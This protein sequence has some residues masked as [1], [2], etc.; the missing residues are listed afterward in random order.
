MRLSSLQRMATGFA[1]APAAHAPAQP[2][3]GYSQNVVG[4]RPSLAVVAAQSVLLCAIGTGLVGGPIGVNGE[5]LITATS[6]ASA[7]VAS[8]APL[9][10]ATPMSTTT[11]DNHKHGSSSGSGSVPA[12]ISGSDI[13][14]SV[15]KP[16][17][18]P[19]TV[20][21][22]VPG[23]M[24]EDWEQLRGSI[25]SRDESMTAYTIFCA[26]GQPSCFLSADAPFVFTE[27]PRSFKYTGVAEPTFTQEIHCSFNVTSAAVCAGTSTV[28]S[29][30][31]VGTVTGPAT[32]SWTK[33]YSS[34]NIT[35]VALTLATPGPHVGTTDIDGTAVA[36]AT[37]GDPYGGLGSEGLFAPT[38]IPKS[39]AAKGWTVEMMGRLGVV[40]AGVVGGMLML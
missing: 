8:A 40:V 18:E 16:A 23:Y 1:A 35:W 28:G 4:R 37:S 24:K 9:D 26:E 29:H 27:G 30:Y 11:A 39:S 32:S 36:S 20:S 34:S 13:I 14:T 33:T 21:I 5:S 38:G 10:I 12:S 3:R 22:W 15:A 6:A 7:A 17:A 2:S 25:V 31:I 19:T